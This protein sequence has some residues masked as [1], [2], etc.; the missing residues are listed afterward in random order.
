[1][2]TNF[3]TFECHVKLAQ[4]SNGGIIFADVFYTH[5]GNRFGAIRKGILQARKY[6]ADEVRRVNILHQY[7][8]TYFEI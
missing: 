1:M 4:H 2:N 7:A 5:T 8:P 6:N 3:Q